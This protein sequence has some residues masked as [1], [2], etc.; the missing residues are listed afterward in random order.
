MWLAKY[1]LTISWNPLGKSAFERER[2]KTSSFHVVH[3]TRT[4]ANCTKMTDACVKRSKLLFYLV[5]Y[6]NLWRC[7]PC[8]LR[9][10]SGD[11]SKGVSNL[12]ILLRKQ[13][14]LHASHARMLYTPGTPGT[15][16][17]C[18]FHCSKFF[19][20]PLRN[21][22]VTWPNLKSFRERQLN[23]DP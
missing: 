1:W 16:G 11:T 9:K 18:V 20:L 15:P 8:C 19:F 23:Y 13:W 14:F 12:H 17:T 7:H 10:I 6:A 2:K 22:D 21:K 4:A 5:K 3:S